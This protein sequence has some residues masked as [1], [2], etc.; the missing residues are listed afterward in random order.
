MRIRIEFD[1]GTAQSA[2]HVQDSAH[3]VIE[4]DFQPGAVPQKVLMSEEP[5]FDPI[6]EA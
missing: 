1:K 5:H 2:R 3:H 6:R 4:S